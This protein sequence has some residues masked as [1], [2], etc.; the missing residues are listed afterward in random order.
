MQI[1]SFGL[2]LN[3]VLGSF[4]TASGQAQV[5]SSLQNG[6]KTGEWFNNNFKM[7]SIDF[8]CAVFDNF[9]KEIA[10]R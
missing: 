10:I 5:N 7:D 4:C 8:G 2:L 3:V 9:F 1:I 6:S